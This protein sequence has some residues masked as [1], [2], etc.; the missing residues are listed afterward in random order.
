M[1]AILNI[2][3]QFAR[4][5][6]WEKFIETMLT[7]LLKK[8]KANKRTEID[9]KVIEFL[10]TAFRYYIKRDIKEQQAIIDNINNHGQIMKLK[11]EAE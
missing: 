2:L 4:W 3:W 6:P 9:D 5:L 11:K 10:L 1:K 7:F 8:A